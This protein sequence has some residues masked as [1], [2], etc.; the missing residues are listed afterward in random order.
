M[1]GMSISRR[2]AAD[3]HIKP[4]AEAKR[5][6]N[7]TSINLLARKSNCAPDKQ[8]QARSTR[9]VRDLLVKQA[10]LRREILRLQL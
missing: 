9:F 6:A 5:I 7:A 2:S 3:A 10:T 1:G 4:L 8:C